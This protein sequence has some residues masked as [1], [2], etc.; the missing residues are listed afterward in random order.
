MD[1]PTQDQ[2]SQDPMSLHRTLVVANRTASTPLLI[3]ELQR[4]VA[5]Q[6]TAFAL[7]VPEVSTR[8]AADWNLETALATIKREL[9]GRGTAGEVPVEG[10]VG[11]ADPFTSVKA[12]LDTGDFHDVIISTL[13]RRTSEWL[14]RDLPRRVRQLGIP[15]T[16]ITPGNDDRNFLADKFKELGP[17]FEIG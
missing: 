2:M 5:A 7:L 13:P 11:G 16:V 14:R 9:R 12:A 4:R 15:V 1:T 8:K 10:L 3:E 17:R 6:P